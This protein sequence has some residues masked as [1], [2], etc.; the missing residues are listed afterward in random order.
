[1]YTTGLLLILNGMSV[2]VSEQKISKL[3]VGKKGLMKLHSRV[4]CI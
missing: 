2:T 1:M 3:S 4:A